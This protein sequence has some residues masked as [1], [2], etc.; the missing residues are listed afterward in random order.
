MI[1]L[2]GT[3]RPKI[4]HALR[5]VAWMSN[6]QNDTRPIKRVKCTKLLGVEI[7]ELLK[8]EKHVGHI[9]SKVSSRI[10]AI[11]KLKEFADRDTLVLVYNALIQLHFDYCCEV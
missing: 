10:G 2:A 3:S 8:W 5:Q 6:S 9:A 11:K 1:L 4:S 7:D